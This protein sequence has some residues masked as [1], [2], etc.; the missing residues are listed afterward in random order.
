MKTRREPVSNV[1]CSY[2]KTYIMD[3][4][5]DTETDYDGSSSKNVKEG[6]T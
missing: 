6:M 4:V 5:N 3:N 1:L 2:Y